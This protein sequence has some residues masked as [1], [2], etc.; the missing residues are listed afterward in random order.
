M[1]CIIMLNKN[2][3]IIEFS[4]GNL[5]ILD[6]VQLVEFIISSTSSCPVCPDGEVRVFGLCYNIETTD[7]LDRSG[8]NLRGEIKDDE[9]A[10]IRGIISQVRWKKF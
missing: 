1:L 8:E 9:V 2:M 4:D 3:N 7:V 6:V 10:L 5:T